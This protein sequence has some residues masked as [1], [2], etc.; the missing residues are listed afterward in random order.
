MSN[1]VY[2]KNNIAFDIDLL[3]TDL[4]GKADVDLTNCT[5]PHIIETYVNGASWYRVWS[6]NWCEQGGKSSLISDYG[7]F[8]INLLKAYVDTNYTITTGG[9][10]N[11]TNDDGAW[12]GAYTIQ[13]P[14]ITTS[15]FTIYSR[16]G[17]QKNINWIACGY[18]N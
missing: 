8:T 12:I 14:T 10:W 18:I 15:S 13:I 3:A 2:N 6:D 11:G 16:S 1:I 7:T 4:N 17:T 9:T 5:K